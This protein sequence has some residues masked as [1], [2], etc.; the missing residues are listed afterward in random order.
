MVG[1]LRRRALR[2]ERRGCSRRCRSAPPRASCSSRTST[3]ARSTSSWSARARQF[4][5]A[6]PRG[7]TAAT[8]KATHFWE[9]TNNNARVAFQPPPGRSRRSSTSRTCR[10]ARADRQRVD[11]RH[12]RAG[13]RVHEVLRGRRSSRSGASSKTFVRG[14]YTWNHYYGNFD[15]DN[16][17]SA[18]TTSTSSSARRT[19]ATAPGASSGTSRTATLRG[20]RPH[21]VKLY[22]YRQLDWNASVGAFFVAQSGQPWET[23]SYEPYRSADDQHERLEPLRRA[24]RARAARDSH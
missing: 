7:S 12:R 14:S 22:G 17:T 6:G 11:L 15:Q 2:R 19:S 18:T 3:R 8:G 24:G 9:D 23:W 5:P 4:G 13:R 20:D 21:L 1:T 10:A 16:S